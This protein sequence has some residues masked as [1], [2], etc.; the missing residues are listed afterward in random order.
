ML[1]AS[2]CARQDSNLQKSLFR[3]QMPFQLSYE[4]EGVAGGIRTHRF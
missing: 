3:G 2:G 4:R 1:F